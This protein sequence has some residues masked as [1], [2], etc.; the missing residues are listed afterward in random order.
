MRQQQ[1]N[2]T[3]NRLDDFQDKN[4]I[5]IGFDLAHGIGNIPLKLHE[6]NVDFATWCSYKYLNSGA[7]GISGVFVHERHHNNTGFKGL[8][9]WWGHKLQDRFNMGHIQ[10]PKRVNKHGKYQIHLCY[11]LFV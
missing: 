1:S 6:W 8:T 10:I 5:K 2:K 4:I 3:W 11:L 7:G 9:G